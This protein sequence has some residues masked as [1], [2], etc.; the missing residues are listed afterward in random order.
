[1]SN[2]FNKKPLDKSQTTQT[3]KPGQHMPGSPTTQ[4][5]AAPGGIQQKT[6]QQKGGLGGSWDKNQT[7]K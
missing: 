6:P 7:S 2:D 1:M 3:G 4:R 5:P